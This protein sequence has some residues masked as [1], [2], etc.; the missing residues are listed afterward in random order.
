MKPL[1]QL[2]A[3]GGSLLVVVI[4]ACSSPAG[5]SKFGAGAGGGSA[6][7]TSGNGNGSGSGGSNA[8][9][10]GAGGG[11][12]TGSGTT[13]TPP[14][15]T[16][17]CKDFPT[18]PVFAGSAPM[19]AP[20]SF[21]G[22]ASGTGPCIL[23]PQM[24]SLFPHNWLRPRVNFTS[25][26]TLFQITFH[27]AVE[28]NDY[29]IYTT[30]PTWT[31]PKTVW[32]AL[33]NNVVGQDVTVTV[34]ASTG[35]G[36]SESTTTF[37]VAPVDAGGSIVFWNATSLT[38][39]T[40]T[41]QL[42]G[43][44][45]GDEGV[46]TALTPTQVQTPMY[47]AAGQLQSAPM[48]STGVASPA[49]TPNCIGCHTSTPDG[50][51]VSFTGDW[52]WNVALAD[53]TAGSV[54]QI[55][56]YVTVAGQ[57]MAQV[58]WQGVTTFSLADWNAGHYRYITSF[59]PRVIS[60]NPSQVYEFWNGAATYT[61]T[62]ADNLI[63]VDLAS[64]APVPSETS[65]NSVTDVPTALVMAEGSLW[66]IIPRTGE[67]TC[68][69]NTA[70]N[71]A[72][73][74]VTPNWSHDGTKIAY[75]YTD[76]TSDGHVG[77][78]PNSSTTLTKAAIY[79]VPFNNGAGGTVT[80]VANEAG[81]GQYYPDFSPDDKYVAYNRVATIP[82]YLY[83]VP[84][85]ELYMTSASGTGTPTRLAAN[86]PPACTGLTTAT[87][88]NSWPKWSPVAAAGP[89]GDTYYFFTF[90]SARQST[91]TI[92]GGGGSPPEAASELFLGSVKVDSMGNVTS[93]PAIYLWNQ[94]D[95]VT[96][97]ATTMVSTVTTAAGTNLTPAWHD[98]V[99]PP[100]PP[101]MTN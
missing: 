54:G 68:P 96:T 48:S 50:K 20:S 67:P 77:H 13:I 17:N 75:T 4:G 62:G 94:H 36:F 99:I 55:P 34:K 85:S 9:F 58:A 91:T 53:V 5:P 6:S 3:V 60:T 19:S 51:A 56:S 23:E 73:G 10:V 45:P 93:Y 87:I 57:T 88:Y 63:W 95:V 70:N 35:S 76:S 98:F 64:T 38:A 52:P 39:D 26:A 40:D 27:A 2:V 33:A 89:N 78:G 90:S 79:T 1:I 32:T 25:T 59:A 7:G 22:T 83:H 65:T 11:A 92:P 101:V 42:Y 84:N 66:G 86:D 46:I 72:C 81:A 24:G 31:M 16:A 71:G 30:E 21:T 82:A 43:F 97:N 8:S 44:S 12:S 41:S 28:A 49:G 61:G 37:S 100:V 18:A 14:T 29:V 47:Q 74:A 80:P 15:C 69:N